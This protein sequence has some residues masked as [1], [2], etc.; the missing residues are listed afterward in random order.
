MLGLADLKRTKVYQEALEEGLE[1]GLQE[2]QKRERQELIKPLLEKL[3]GD[4]DEAWEEA[5]VSSAESV[6]QLLILRNN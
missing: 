4:R 6:S 2:G 5:I 1:P 3:F